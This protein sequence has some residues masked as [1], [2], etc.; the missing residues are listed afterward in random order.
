MTAKKTPSVETANGAV[1][2]EAEATY[3]ITIAKAMTYLGLVMRP[4]DTNIKVTG[5]ALLA[6]GRDAPKGAIVNVEKI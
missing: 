3:K 4:S 5:E 1:S 6:I 2:V